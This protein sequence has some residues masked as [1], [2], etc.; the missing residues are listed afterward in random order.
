MDR[1]TFRQHGLHWLASVGVILTALIGASC[2]AQNQSSASRRLAQ[3]LDARVSLAWQGQQLAAGLG[4]FAESQRIAIWIDRRVDPTTPIEIEVSEQPLRDALAALAAPRAWAATPYQGVLYFGPKQ[5]AEELPTLSALA[6][7][8]IAKAPAELRLRWLKPEPWSFPRLSEPRT[9]L[10]QLAESVGAQVDNDHLVPHDLW[11]SRS[12]PPMSAVDR[13]VLLLSGFD[14]TCE[15]SPDGRKLRIVPIERPVQITRTYSVSRARR[16]AVDAVITEMPLAKV[17]R[18]GQGGLTLS[19]SVESHERVQ[20][21]MRGQ[22]AQQVS[23]PPQRLPGATD[24]S[25]R[26]TLKI[27]NQ[28]AGRIIDQ[29]AR[30]LQLEVE[31]DAALRQTPAVGHEA[32]VSCDVRDSDLD[33]LLTAVLSPAGLAFERDG[34]V[35]KIRRGK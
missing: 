4:R 25:K 12:L 5:T 33:G 20:A 35:V 21:A 30:Q 27:E 22:S 1:S 34:Q 32:I 28:P 16:A 14:L 23:Q 2:P 29:L 11:P 3:Q 24:A 10:N 9:L 13:V 7:Q 19:A 17:E 26:F 15:L 8:S 6:R 18:R 31:W